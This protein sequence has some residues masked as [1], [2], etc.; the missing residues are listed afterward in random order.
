[1]VKRTIKITTVLLIL[2]MIV[3][4][5]ILLNRS[6]LAAEDIAS[7]TSGTCSWV[8]DSEGILTISPRN[9]ESGTLA[10]YTGV[11]APAGQVPWYSTRETITKVIVEEGV[12]TSIGCKWL[13]YGL[14][15]CTEMD[16]SKL[17]TSDCTTMYG[18]FTNC[19]IVTS[20]E[21]ISNWDT[22]N[23]TD[24]GQ[25][26]LNCLKLENV[27]VSNF[28]TSNV[29]IMTSMF[30]SCTSLTEIDVSNFDTSNVTNMTSLFSG[31]SSLSEIDVSN[32]DVSSVTGMN[33]LFRGIG[34]T[35]LDLST[36]HP[37]NVITFANMFENCP[38]L[39]CVIF[40][41]NWSVTNNLTNMKNMFNGCKML[42]TIDSLK[43]NTSKVTDMSR[44]FCNCEKIQSLDLSEW[45]TGSCT[46][47]E[48]MFDHCESIHTLDVSS[49]N[50]SK[51]TNMNSMFNCCFKALTYID[52]SGF[53]TGNVTNMHCMFENCFKLSNLD[54]SGF[55]T[56]KVTDMAGMFFQGYELTSLDVTG[57]DTSNVTTMQGMFRL[58]TKL[59]DL[60]I[61]GFDTSNV[62]N[63][64]YMFFDCRSLSTL[65]VSG[66]NTEKVTSMYEIFTG[67]SSL[68]YLDLSNFNTSK[69]TNMKEFLDRCYGLESITLGEE[70]SFKGINSGTIASN[71]SYQA[72]L[73]T[74]ESTVLYTGKWI[75]DDEE[76]GP[77]TPEFL[78][79]NY[80]GS[81][82]AGT[83]ILEK[84]NAKFFVR[85]SYTGTIPTGA[86]ELPQDAEYQYG[87]S[88]KVEEEATAPGYT[89]SGWSTDDFSMPANDVEIT[90]SFTAN[91][92]TS[93]KV[94]HYLED[95]TTGTYI[96]TETENLTG[97]TDGTKSATPKTF[98]GYTFDNTIEG[99]IQSGTIAGDGSLV[100]KLY[101]RKNEI[102]I[103]NEYNY[104][105]EYF[106]D[107]VIDEDLEQIINAEVNSEVTILP[108]TPIKH[109]NRNYTLV[110]K[111]HN[112]TISINEEDN[113]IKVYY[114]T[115]VLDYAID[116]EED[117]IE[118]DG[119][120]DKYQIQINYKVQ[121]G[122]WDDETNE[123]KMQIV[124]LY[125]ENEGL[126]EE[127]TGKTSIPQVGN[128]PNEGYSQGS[129]NKMIPSEVSIKDNGIE[130]VYSYAKILK[131][132]I[133][134]P[135][136]RLSN[137]KTGDK[138]QRYIIYVSIGTLILMTAI[139]IRR[140]Y[141]RKARKIQY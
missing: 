6:S 42:Q 123:I 81:T 134:E 87:D 29:T 107:G 128:K 92:N 23:V 11:N 83:W 72:I 55:N 56:S 46:T 141:S 99:T 100:L 114:E 3:S 80:N 1:M 49:F 67:C 73:P 64:E 138:V 129:W 7:G 110:S 93:Y 89:F 31:C 47:M 84:T 68:K 51:V 15:R 121:N 13:F 95:L 132:D 66:F 127:G 22:S 57:F 60:D 18:M 54:V 140:K 78:R 111:N 70:F 33:Y 27:D 125:D 59:E 20:I 130:Y 61:S 2:S 137:P 118:G 43:F 74:P 40:G 69:V 109:G 88:V 131:A 126:S 39:N 75:R 96:L 5:I 120:P 30:S 119:I 34:V 8:I 63:I 77:Y 26:F 38:N 106:F 139:K 113:I 76:Y 115:D 122:F 21:G 104:K 25:L 94:E 86:S 45:D 90:G 37:H 71:T 117:E 32:W 24:M 36:W 9:G 62:T 103:E 58:C 133:I 91:S 116:G 98:P 44:V 82:M 48:Y 50:T 85:Y 108:I 35:S 105:V 97:K 17:D 124:T 102:P 16:L 101:Y 52:V 79:D 112:I 135:E 136:R 10:S 65:D 28:N 53:D 4:L 41:D 14:N 12:K 19:N